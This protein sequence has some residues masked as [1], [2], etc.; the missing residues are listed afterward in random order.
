MAIMA[1][2]TK[3]L[4][5][6][7]TDTVLRNLNREIMG[8]Q[9]RTRAGLRGA[10]LVVR[11]RSQELTPVATGHLRASTYTETYNTSEGY[12]AEIGYM[13]GYAPYV[14]EINKNY[15]IGQWKFLETALKEK[16]REILEIIKKRARPRMG[17]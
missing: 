10:V 5:I 16:S 8:I 6:T 2:G 14:H 7:G 11:K 17:R 4:V 12:G 9:N 1:V 15:T 3:A 13:A